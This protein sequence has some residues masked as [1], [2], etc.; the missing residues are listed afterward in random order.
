MKALP[1]YK[2]VRAGEKDFLLLHG[3]LRGFMPEK[4]MDEYNPDDIFWCRP[5][6]DTEYFPDK[7]VI[8]GHTSTRF[9]YEKAGETVSEERF[10][11]AGTYTAIDCG[12]AFPGGRLGC[13]C[14]D[15]M[16]EIYV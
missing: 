16:E 10:F 5:E 3:G 15:T 7:R 11:Y 12:C 2:E 6:P 8:L 4:P 9:L 1:L 14:L 13:L